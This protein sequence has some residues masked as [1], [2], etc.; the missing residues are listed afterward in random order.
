[1]AKERKRDKRKKRELGLEETPN[2]F[3]KL[4]QGGLVEGEKVG[5]DGGEMGGPK[6]TRCEFLAG[7]VGNKILKK[8]KNE[9]P[10]SEAD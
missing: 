3:E 2:R 10:K 6:Y 5:K 4:T 1:M 7:V 8:K 9:P